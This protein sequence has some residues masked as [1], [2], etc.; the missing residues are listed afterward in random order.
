MSA[1]LRKKWKAYWK[2]DERLEREW[3]ERGYIG[4]PKRIPFPDELKDLTCGAKTRQGHPCKIS[5]LY[6]NGRCQFHGGLSTGPNSEEGKKR[7]SQNGLL[8]KK[9]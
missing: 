3:K 6:G 2:E 5:S 9:S 1:E 4:E 7:S 8:P